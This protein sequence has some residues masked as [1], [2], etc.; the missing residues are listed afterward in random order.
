MDSVLSGLVVLLLFLL[1]TFTLTTRFFEAQ[2]EVQEAWQ[3]MESRLDDQS[4]T[5]LTPVAAR[6]AGG[7]TVAE[8]TYRNTG[9]NRLV[10]FDQWDIIV[11]YYTQDAAEYHVRWVPIN[12]GG[13]LDNT[14]KVSGIY[15]D[16]AKA[17]PEVFE[18]GILNPGEE[19]VIQIQVAP[20]V[21]HGQT[22]LAL[23]IAGNGAGV[24][25][26]AIRNVPPVLVVNTG[27]TLESRTSADILVTHLQAVDLDDLPEDLVFT[28]MTPPEQ[29][30]LN[31]PTTFTQTQIDEDALEYT[32][33]GDGN[34]SFVFQVSDGED[35]IGLYTFTIMTT[36]AAPVLATNSIITVPE[37]ASGSIP[38]AA[39]TATDVD[40]L[41]A[42]LVYTIISGP[43]L[44]TLTPGT[45][46]TQA[47][48]DAGAVGYS[49]LAAGLDSFQFTIT[50]GEATIGPFT[51]YLAM[52]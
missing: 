50:D 36:N 17:Q 52:P 35:V 49:R 15:Q 26:Q 18:N 33:T 2:N 22:L 9:E 37:G 51:F 41:P 45:T 28:V 25:V 32:H 7:G 42:E 3:T 30:E 4:R 27:L 40:N 46:F 31:L 29:G 12:R 23:V 43:T 47:D 34:D 16:A 10:N 38:A 13:A 5:S 44:G 11:Q 19:I 21:G 8:V 20:G 48:L 39:L 24:S 14:W 6:I 1:A